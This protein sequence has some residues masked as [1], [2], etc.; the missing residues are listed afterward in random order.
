MKDD[1]KKAEAALSQII[2]KGYANNDPV[3]ISGLTDG[4][5]CIGIGTDA[6]VFSYAEE[7]RYAF[8]VYSEHA[9]EKLEAEKKVYKLLEG[10][11]YHPR[12]YGSGP[13]YLVISY[14]SGF[15]LYECLVHGIPV[16]EQVI[17]DV[18]D[19]KRF[20]I[21][22]GL[23]PRDIH[24]KNVLL[25]DGR[26][27]VIDV[28]EYIKEGNDHRWDH[29]VWAYH[30][31]YGHLSGV[32]IPSWALATIRNWYNRADQTN[33]SLEEFSQRISKLFKWGSK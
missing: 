9:M 29:L 15:T 20:V 30:Q 33:F 28:S 3:T 31:F 23:N 11:P 13:N 8:K 19:A 4:L 27:K 25:Q 5:H 21:E 12:Y 7:P 6:A 1:W 22:R 14:E 17:V 10:S 24:L 2:V 32:K 18:E 16:P 26:A